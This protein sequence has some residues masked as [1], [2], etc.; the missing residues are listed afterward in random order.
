MTF[1]MTGLGTLFM[2]ALLPIGLQAAPQIEDD[3]PEISVQRESV[4]QVT[5]AERATLLKTISSA[6][7][8]VK[9]AK[10]RFTQQDAN[11]NIVSG[12]FYLRRPGRV[13]FE[14][15]A[16]SPLLIVSDG[17]TV[18][19]EDTDLE[20]QDRVPLRA[21]PLSLILDDQLDFETRT[22]ILDV[23]RTETVI[24]ITLEDSTGE[25]EGRLLLVVDASDYNLVE[26]Q[27]IAP[28][29]GVTRVE[30]AGVETGLRLNPR[31]FRIEDLDAEDERD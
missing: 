14:Y 1:S 13:R 28:D 23:S 17:A 18:A 8:D 9:T 24:G 2:L 20:T 22:N 26:W 16:P 21:T 7:S 19:I 11:Y 12:D 5:G 6:L 3:A 30:L 25:T 10:G 4:V 27:A 15:D 31:L 29:G